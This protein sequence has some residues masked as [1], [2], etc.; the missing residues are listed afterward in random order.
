MSRSPRYIN[1]MLNA[2]VNV[3][4]IEQI[5]SRSSSIINVSRV[6]QATSHNAL[7]ARVI[8][9]AWLSYELS[10]QRYTGILYS[11]RRAHWTSRRAALGITRCSSATAAIKSFCDSARITFEMHTLQLARSQLRVVAENLT[12]TSIPLYSLAH[13][14]QSNVE[15][16]T[17]LFLI[18]KNTRRL[19]YTA[20][21]SI[22]RGRF[23]NTTGSRGSRV[24]KVR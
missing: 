20:C 12:Q 3:E 13:L 17:F 15:K 4:Q 21:T 7:L 6:H 1:E 2:E 24:L 22:T 23:A 14:V 10:K 18:V 16:P 19:R 8:F 5:E 9:A 11:S